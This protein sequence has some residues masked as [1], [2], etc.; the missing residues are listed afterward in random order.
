[1]SPDEF[2]RNRNALVRY[3]TESTTSNEVDDAF[4][5]LVVT[6]SRE[7]PESAWELILATIRDTAPGTDLGKL[8]AGP[9]ENLLAAHGAQFIER[10]ERELLTNLRF[11]D[12]LAHVWKSNTEQ[13][14]WQRLH[15]FVLGH[16]D[17]WQMKE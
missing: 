4:L 11:R 2:E 8:G 5:D 17:E 14:V 9:L 3:F 13:A 10:I 15:D 16:R 6:H 12:V 1:M 7:D